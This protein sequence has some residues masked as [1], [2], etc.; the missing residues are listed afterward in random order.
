MQLTRLPLGRSA[1]VAVASAVAILLAF[2]GVA[3]AAS[4]KGRHATIVGTPGNDVIVGKRASDV[5]YGGGGNDR[6]SG[7]PNGND[8][9][10]GGPGNDVI[11]GGRGYD[12]LFGEGGDDRLNGE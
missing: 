10:C 1:V 9:I 5:I 2:A 6:I 7:G 8:R 4:C 11:R 3:G 12:S